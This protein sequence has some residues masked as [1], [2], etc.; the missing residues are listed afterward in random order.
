MTDKYDILLF[1]WEKYL[2]EKRGVTW[3]QLLNRFVK[4][5]EYLHIS[6]RTL[7]KYLKQ[8]IEEGLLAKQIDKESLS[9]VYFIPKEAMGKVYEIK[10]K[11]EW[12]KS[13]MDVTSKTLLKLLEEEK[14][15]SDYADYWAATYLRNLNNILKDIFNLNDQEYRRL[16]EEFEKERE[17]VK[18]VKVKGKETIV[19][20][21]EFD[22]EEFYKWLKK[23]L[24]P[25]V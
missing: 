16:Q 17:L 18:T 25:K 3:T 8:L 6:K 10:M 24:K 4:G 12:I 7:S 21:R 2:P 1:I 20:A 15:F 9:P 13:V 23:K 14:M 11:K 22:Y 19:G 5:P